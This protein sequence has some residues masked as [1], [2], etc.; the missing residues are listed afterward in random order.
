MAQATYVPNIAHD[1]AAALAFFQNVFQAIATNNSGA[2]APTETF[3]GMWW[4]DTSTTPPTLRQRNQANSAWVVFAP[5]N[6]TQAQVEDA[7]STVFGLVNGELLSQAIAAQVP[8]LIPPSL[9][10]TSVVSRSINVTYT[11]SL[12]RPIFVAGTSL[13]STT[14]DRQ[15]ELRVDY[16]S[17]L[18]GVLAV[19]GVGTSPRTTCGLVPAGAQWRMETATGNLVTSQV[20]EFR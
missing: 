14:N 5:P 2:T 4:L 1:N 13:Y 15:M 3:A 7:A 6:L 20:R 11:N 17:G 12:T 16:G 18:V 9:Q 19:N 8:A 10:A